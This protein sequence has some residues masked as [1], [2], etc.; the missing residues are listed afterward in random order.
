MTKE[1]IA[2]QTADHLK[3]IE[4]HGLTVD[5]SPYSFIVHGNNIK[6]PAAPKPQKSDKK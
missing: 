5:R 2:K 4:K 6:H 1:E 3:S